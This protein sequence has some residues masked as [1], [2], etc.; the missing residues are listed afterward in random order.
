[1]RW[2]KEH[3]VD[4]L[5]GAETLWIWCVWSAGDSNRLV[6]PFY[7]MCQWRVIYLGFSGKDRW[8]SESVVT[9]AGCLWWDVARE[10]G[11]LEKHNQIFKSRRTQSLFIHANTWI[12]KKLNGCGAQSFTFTGCFRAL[13]CLDGYS[14]DC[15]KKY[16]NPLAW[17]G[18][19]HNLVIW[20][21]L[22]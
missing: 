10:T 17:P 12:L 13:V 21:D 18:F 4:S 6:E 5:W 19:L 22:I 8:L 20:C 11:Q 16:A 14:Y 15:L 1:M 3:L 9:P 7:S 2:H